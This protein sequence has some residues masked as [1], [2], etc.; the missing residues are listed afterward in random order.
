MTLLIL[1]NEIGA[2]NKAKINNQQYASDI[3]CYFWIGIMKIHDVCSENYHYHHE[4]MQ[5]PFSNIGIVTGFEI[6]GII[7]KMK[8]WLYLVRS[9]ILKTSG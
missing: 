7:L 2:T 9:S 5:N 1:K 6:L 4:E 3:I 8:I